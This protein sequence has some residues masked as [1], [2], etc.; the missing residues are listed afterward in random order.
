MAEEF[1]SL[2]ELIEALEGRVKKLEEENSRLRWVA[3]N[4]YHDS[5]GGENP[6]LGIEIVLALEGWASGDNSGR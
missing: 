2:K 4:L 5:N 3:Q 6:V 1:V